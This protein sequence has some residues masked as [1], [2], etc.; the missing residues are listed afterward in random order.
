MS[1]EWRKGELHW[2]N[3]KL[4]SLRKVNMAPQTIWCQPEEN[5]QEKHSFEAIKVYIINDE[6]GKEQG[7]IVLCPQHN[8]P[9]PVT[10][11]RRLP[12]GGQSTL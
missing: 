3:A 2:G 10:V 7:G 8:K 1:D 4:R 11:V 9:I 5:P 6:Q 12:R